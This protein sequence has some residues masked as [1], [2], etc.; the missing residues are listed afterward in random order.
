MLVQ[1]ACACC[2][3]VVLLPG[4]PCLWGL[5]NWNSKWEIESYTITYGRSCDCFGFEML[6]PYGVIYAF[7]QSSADGKTLAICIFSYTFTK[8]FTNCSWEPAKWGR[9]TILNTPDIEITVGLCSIETC[10]AATQ[11]FSWILLKNSS[12]SLLSQWRIS[13]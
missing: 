9:I 12:K 3:S 2:D 6:C 4:L 7:P 11:W 1:Q 8:M 13:D 5:I 10:T